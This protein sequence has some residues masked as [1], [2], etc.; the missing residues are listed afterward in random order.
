MR[1]TLRLRPSMLEA[2]GT[3]P[4]LTKR[5]GS[6]KPKRIAQPTAKAKVI[7]KRIADIELNTLR[8]I[9]FIEDGSRIPT[10]TNIET[11]CGVLIRGSKS[12]L[13]ALVD[14]ELIEEFEEQV[15]T[16]SDRTNVRLG[17]EEV[18]VRKWQRGRSLEVYR[19][20]ELGAILLNDVFGELESFV[21]E[22]GRPSEETALI[23]G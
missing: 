14:M 18:Y 2:I 15:I 1:D 3:Y 5:H 7:G 19:A 20:T 16:N 23:Q 10:D 17:W 22:I 4:A 9:R 6:V 8:S 13:P 21:P 11:I 12:P